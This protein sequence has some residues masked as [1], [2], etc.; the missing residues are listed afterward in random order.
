MNKE[1]LSFNKNGASIVKLFSVVVMAVA[2]L[3]FILLLSKITAYSDD[4]RFGTFFDYGLLHFWDQTVSHYMESNGRLLVHFLLELTLLADT[5]IYMLL[6]PAVVVL[7]AYLIC[8]VFYKQVSLLEFSAVTS[9]SILLLLGLPTV[10]LSSSILWMSGSFNFVLPLAFVLLGVFF[11]YR[12][13]ERKTLSFLS[14]FFCFIAGATTEQYGFY[15]CIAIWG[16]WIMALVRKTIPL[17][18]FWIAP[19]FVVIGYLTVLLAPGMWG[20]VDSETLGFWSFLDPQLLRMR[21]FD[22]SVEYFDWN[23][24]GI[25]IVLFVLLSASLVFSR[26]RYSRLLLIGYPVAIFLACA[27]GI[28]A[29]YSGYVFFLYLLLLGILFVSK[30]DTT[31]LGCLL[32]GGLGT[33]LILLITA[34]YGYR[35]TM[36]LLFTLIL[37]AA[38]FAVEIVRGRR[39]LWYPIVLI[40][41]GLFSCGSYLT[42]YRGYSAAKVV[43]DENIEAMKTYRDIGELHLSLDVNPDYGYTPFYENDYFYYAYLEYYD[44]DYGKLD[45]YLDGLDYIP[46]YINGEK[47]GVP[48]YMEEDGKIYVP[49][50]DLAKSFGRYRLNEDKTV[51]Y[52]IN[53]VKYYQ[54]PVPGVYKT[55]RLYADKNYETV[56]AEENDL[57][58]LICSFTFLSDTKLKEIFA[59]EVRYDE[60]QQCC[61]LEVGEA[62]AEES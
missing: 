35:T 38:Y 8:A 6:C 18:K 62:S 31:V 2:V 20:R 43:L 45:I 52:K 12:S 9:L 42:T 32:L 33:Q 29:Y 21:F 7:C 28:Y 26:Q 57:L 50:A 14:V 19:L 17:R 54:Q 36:P 49:L 53:G 34:V 27:N 55:N 10:F 59:M 40:G 48:C 15:A 23:G 60:E 4:Y 1:N 25:F 61:F 41:V 47:A 30:K 39:L 58:T 24:C 44:V 16:M 13:I 22:I 37:L 51:T 11:Y 5:K 46:L 56:L 3:L